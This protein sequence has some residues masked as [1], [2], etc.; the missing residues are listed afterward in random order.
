[1]M[2][3]CG[4]FLFAHLLIIISLVNV[5][6]GQK[7]DNSSDVARRLVQSAS[8]HPG[9]VVFVVGGK[10]M[11]PLME[12][13]A[14]EVLNRGGFAHLE[15][16]SELVARA[17]YTV[18]PEKHLE[19]EPR[20]FGEWLKH[21]NVFIALPTTA[22]PK[23]LLDGV[24]EARLAKIAKSNSYL[25]AML[26][27]LPVRVMSIDFPTK[28]AA[29]MWGMEFAAFEKMTNN[30]INADYSAIS[31]KGLA[32]KRI[33][34]NAK[35]IKVTN[36]AGT[37]VTFTMASG[38]GI[39]VDDGIV[40]AEEGQS[41]LFFQRVASLPSGTVTFAPL[42]TSANGRV[43]VRKDICRFAPLTDVSFDFKDGKLQN[44]KAGAN[45]ACFSEAMNAYT[46]PKDTFGSV[47]IGLNPAMRVV[48]EGTA[49]LLPANA[50]GMVHLG[51]GNNA[52]LGGANTDTQG[53]FGFPI[54]HA[55]VTIDG[56]VVIKD[57]KLLF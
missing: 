14:I 9:D 33:L 38:R 1:M 17:R 40:T 6:N 25:E 11:I 12:A 3:C 35:Q 22:D 26:N 37:E 46:G 29:E 42:E 30:A 2:K 16:E 4:K 41:K 52:F 13:I 23:A 34:E 50:A 27:S 15:L 48:D 28:Q 7:S 39:L 8:V 44:F 21:T 49:N 55:T 43:R 51:I 19:Q 53:G 45:G 54:P 57:G 24:P 32:L 47:T 36:A 5:A 18:V 31:Q 20:F 10:Q 56:R